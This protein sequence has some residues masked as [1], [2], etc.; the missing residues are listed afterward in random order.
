MSVIKAK[1]LPD[2][3]KKVESIQTPMNKLMIELRKKLDEREEPTTFVSG[4]SEWHTIE[5]F[6][7]GIV[8][9]HLEEELN[10]TPVICLTVRDNL[11]SLTASLLESPN[12][13]DLHIL[14]ENNVDAS[15][16]FRVNYLCNV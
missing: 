16:S 13:K 14:V 9:I 6:S 1:A 2:E 4:S 5:P 8:M 12:K 3:V 11:G 10:A 7:S 15:R